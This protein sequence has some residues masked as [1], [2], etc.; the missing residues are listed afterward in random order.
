MIYSYLLSL[1]LAQL[2]EYEAPSEN[3]NHLQQTV[4]QTITTRK[5]P[6]VDLN[7]SLILPEDQETVK[8]I[9]K[10]L[11]ILTPPHIYIDFLSH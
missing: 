9:V 10:G 5:L 3:W 4:N 1:V 6:S 2:Q 11:A 7:K 8:L